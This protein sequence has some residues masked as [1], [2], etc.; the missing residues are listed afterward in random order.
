MPR[1]GL[2]IN[3]SFDNRPRAPK[4]DPYGRRPRQVS[5]V[6]VVGERDKTPLFSTLYAKV[7]TALALL[8]TASTALAILRIYTFH[9]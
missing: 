5:G 2:S 1:L 6:H 4:P 8:A 7:L 9:H 3:E